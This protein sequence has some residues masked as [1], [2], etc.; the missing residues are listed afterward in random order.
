MA[1]APTNNFTGNAQFGK[2]PAFPTV[3]TTCSTWILSSR[4]VSL[5]FGSHSYAH[6]SSYVSYKLQ[7]DLGF[8]VH[9]YSLL[10]SIAC[11]EVERCA[12]L[13]ERDSDLDVDVTYRA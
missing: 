3:R 4:A 1:S 11:Q 10:L 12:V 13:S 8:E 9:Y 2:M 5:P 6:D 7:S